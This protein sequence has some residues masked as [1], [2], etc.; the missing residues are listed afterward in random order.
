MSPG[1]D[2]QIMRPEVLDPADWRHQEVGWGLILPEPD[3]LTRAQLATAGDAPEPIQ[4]LVAERGGKVLR[5][6]AESKYGEWALRDY[7]GGATG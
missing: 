1:T 3:G 5:Y 4:K 6:R 7:A 2:E